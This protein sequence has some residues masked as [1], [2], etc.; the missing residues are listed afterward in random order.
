VTIEPCGSPDR[1]T[2]RGTQSGTKLLW[3]LIS[4][5]GGDSYLVSPE[6]R[7]SLL[8]LGVAPN[9]KQL[10]RT[11]LLL[12]AL[13]HHREQ[14]YFYSPRADMSSNG[15]GFGPVE[16]RSDG[17]FSTISRVTTAMA[18]RLTAAPFPISTND[19]RHNEYLSNASLGTGAPAKACEWVICARS[20]VFFESTTDALI[21]A[22]FAE[23]QFVERESDK[24]NVGAVAARRDC[25]GWNWAV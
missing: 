2:R 12:L 25:L 18:V 23:R 3:R 21:L 5:R 6:K 15:F 14:T 13:R 17:T 9:G 20:G 19:R 16:R 24:Q 22:G 10:L 11:G 8:A 7:V 4:K 1:S